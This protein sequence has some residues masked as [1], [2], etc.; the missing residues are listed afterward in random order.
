MHC[1]IWDAHSLRRSQP[2]DVWIGLFL[3]K[4]VLRDFML[5]PIKNYTARIYVVIFCLQ[6]FGIHDSG[7][8]DYLYEAIRK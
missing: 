8:V 1:E 4:S 3:C 6:W 2:P 7:H 5:M